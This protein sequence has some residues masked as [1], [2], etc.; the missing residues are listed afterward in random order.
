MLRISTVCLLLLLT[1]FAQGNLLVNS[2]FQAGLDHWEL[3]GNDKASIHLG[4]G[5]GPNGSNC[6]VVPVGR[7]SIAETMKL[8]PRTT[9]ELSFVYRRSEPGTKGGLVFFLNRTGGINASAGVINLEFPQQPGGGWEE[10]REAFRTPSGTSTGKVI[11]SA[12]GSGEIR[13]ARIELKEVPAAAD[14]LPTS[15]WSR[16]AGTR[17]KDPIFHELL[18][19]QPGNYTVVEWTH[20]MNKDRLPPSMADKYTNEQ[21][22]QEQI[23][24]YKEAGE[25]GLHHYSLPWQG[26]V[27]GEMFDRFGMKFDSMCES[28]GVMANAIKAGAELLN[29]VRSSTT[30]ARRVASLV[31]PIYVSTAVDE[32]KKHAERFAGKPFVF[33]YCGKDEPSIAIS[34]GPASG[35]GPFGK[36][37]AKETLDD[38]GFGRYGIP[39]PGDPAF[40]QDEANHPFRWIAFNRWMADRYAESKK[41]I[42]AALKSVDPNARYIPCDF[43]FMTGFQPYDFALMGKYGDILECDP[44]G[45]SAER[46]R[47]RGLYNHGFGAKFLSDISGKP[48]RVI[49]Q[50]FDY[51]GYQMTPENLLDWVSQA[52][53]CGASHISY[54]QMDNPRFTDPERWKMMLHLS[55]TLTSMNRVNLPNDPEVAILYS[56]DSHRAEGPSTKANEVYT[57]YSLLGER[58]GSW[59]DIVDDDSLARGEK[60][61]AKY[62]VVYVPLATYQ[63]KEIARQIERFVRDGGTVVSGDPTVF[64]RDI[65][66]SDLSSWRERIFGVKVIGQK[67]RNSMLV[68]KS[69]WTEGVSG[70]LPIYR[71]IGR[72]GWPKDNG[73]MIEK[74]RPDVQ[75]IGTFAD[76]SPAITAARYGKGRAIYFAANPFVPECLFEG[77]RWDGLFKALQT[78]L[79]AKVDRPIWRFRLPPPD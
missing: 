66:G 35:W 18:S 67:P 31:D 76:G 73:C 50:A 58:V 20:N 33:V 27:A 4:T 64:S 16:L 63:R 40:L 5:E 6:A 23:A 10:F 15:D 47:G 51:A 8:K 44:Y 36:Q 59:F 60:S 75:V 9:Y 69:E 72:D 13:Y 3:Y 34:E 48:V 7:A 17:T 46:M 26:D 28:S 37:C 24:M 32:I 45:S 43:W 14:L 77:D 57:A 42:S 19:N 61:L 38:Y 30:S 79:G 65:D 74:A 78:H 68:R 21:W 54:Y 41:T 2:G 62:R 12:R 25:V 1:T 52:V 29:P 49:V 39:A 22:K 53:R 70:S 71:P 56:A 55:K 11:L